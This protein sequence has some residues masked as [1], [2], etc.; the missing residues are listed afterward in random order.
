[1]FPFI[2]SSKVIREEH[3]HRLWVAMLS[4]EFGWT[5]AKTGA[6]GSNLKNVVYYGG[7][8]ATIRTYM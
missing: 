2:E 7:N 3:P 8:S 4:F 1:M 6:I 5:F